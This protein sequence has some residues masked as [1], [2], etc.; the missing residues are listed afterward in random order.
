MRSRPDRR[1]VSAVIGL[2]A[3]LGP[4]GTGS[5]EAQDIRVF[6]SVDLEGISGLVSGSQMS[7]GGPDY[8]MGRSLAE[9]DTNAAIG[10]AFDAGASTVVVID[11]HGSKTNPRP[12]RVDPRAEL[13]TGNQRPLGMIH[14]IDAT[15]D[16]VVFIGY[17]ARTGTTDAIADH[18]YTGQLKR[19]AFNGIELGEAGLAG[20]VAG[21]TGCLS[22]SC[23]VTW[24][25]RKRPSRS[26][27]ASRRWR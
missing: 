26:S 17:H 25:Q 12:D 23:R 20:A 10:A 18:T 13:V 9:A 15:F 19:I 24:P 6:I 3:T 8:G 2:V 21:T 1:L 14:G 4:L 27:Q 5:A 22:S 7:S 11:S 16:A